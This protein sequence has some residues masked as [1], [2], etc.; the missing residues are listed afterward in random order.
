MAGDREG[1]A[2]ET[3]GSCAQWVFQV[4]WLAVPKKWTQWWDTVTE[5]RGGA[6]K[7]RRLYIICR[8]SVLMAHTYFLVYLVVVVVWYNGTVQKCSP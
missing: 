3:S 6:G 8:C 1:G 2:L 4:G 7:R 5:G